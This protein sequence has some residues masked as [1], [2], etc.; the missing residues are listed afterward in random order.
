M[1]SS[2]NRVSSA[3]VAKRRR[4][5]NLWVEV[6]GRFTLQV[7]S[8]QEFRPMKLDPVRRRRELCERQSTVMVGLQPQVQNKAAI[9]SLIRR[10]STGRL[11]ATG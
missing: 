2:R 10:S 6:I 5:R 11:S 9:Q 1:L 7:R 3:A 4:Q 8:P